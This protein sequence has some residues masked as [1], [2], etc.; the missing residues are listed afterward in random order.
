MSLF[1]V[2]H[3][4]TFCEE[5]LGIQIQRLITSPILLLTTSAYTPPA[6]NGG[7][8]W[9]N[10]P[11]RHKSLGATSLASSEPQAMSDSG[12]SPKASISPDTRD[13]AP[14][15]TNQSRATYY[16]PSLISIYRTCRNDKMYIVKEF[17]PVHTVTQVPWWYTFWTWRQDND[18]QQ[19]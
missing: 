12:C 10:L 4:G 17:T 13:T 19:S 6:G 14:D 16:I 3:P 9:I 5:M 15:T 11:D 2:I 7:P 8:S 1:A 18:A